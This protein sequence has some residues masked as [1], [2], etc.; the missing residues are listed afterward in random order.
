MKNN[1]KKLRKNND[2][3]EEIVR[4]EKLDAYESI[5]QSN[6]LLKQKILNN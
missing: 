4:L 3:Y 6:E 2:P 5:I 1:N